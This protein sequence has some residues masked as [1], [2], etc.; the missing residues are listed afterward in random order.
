MFNL[1]NDKLESA[2]QINVSEVKL[3]N[4]AGVSIDLSSMWVEIEVYESIFSPCISGAVTVHD[5]YNLSRNFPLIGVETL[6]LTYK[7]PTVEEEVQKKFRIYDMSVKERIPGK[8]EMIFTLQFVSERHLMDQSTKISR[9]FKNKKWTEIARTIFRD[10]LLSDEERN[11]GVGVLFDFSLLQEKIVIQEDTLAPTSVIIPN[12][13]P[14]HALNWICGKAEYYGNCD[15]VFFEG[16]DI[17]YF[18][19]LSYFK[20]LPPVATYKYNTEKVERN[21][22]K[23]VNLEMKKILQYS[24]VLNGNNKF[25]MDAEGLFASRMIVHDVTFKTIQEKDFSYIRDFNDEKVVRLSKYPIAPL[26]Y[27][28]SVSPLHKLYYKQKSSF[29]F[30]N[31]RQQYDP[32]HS[33][34]RNSQLLRN[35]GKVLNVEVFGDTR[36]RVGQILN[37]EITSP[38]FL[39]SK[40]QSNVIDGSI[41]GKY[42]VSS[43]GHKIRKQDGHFMGLELIKDSFDE[44]IP[45]E[46][47]LA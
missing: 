13:S 19:S 31:I 1:F 37:I 41:S 35:N 20:N 46:V 15:Y 25:E 9:S 11:P 18:V 28:A 22:G 2:G 10:Y 5:K 42:M 26:T 36:R 16:L 44:A 27:V 40:N 6:Y 47:N 39:M 17:S 30:S 23:D 29:A 43:I 24:E 33:Q 7:T 21:V 3:V 4:H 45:D 8:E 34:K 38:E 32:F 14:F 12:W